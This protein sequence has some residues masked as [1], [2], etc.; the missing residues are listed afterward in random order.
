MLITFVEE[1]KTIYIY[2]IPMSMGKHSYRLETTV[3]EYDNK[4]LKLINILLEL[5]VLS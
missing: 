4:I 2:K 5:S 1:I 3:Y